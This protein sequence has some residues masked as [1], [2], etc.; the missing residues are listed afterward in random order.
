MSFTTLNKSEV[1]NRIKENSAKTE[2]SCTPILY[3]Q[4]LDIVNSA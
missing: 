4:V 3:Q 2:L 1:I